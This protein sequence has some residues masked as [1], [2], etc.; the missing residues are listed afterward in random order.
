MPRLSFSAD[1]FAPGEDLGRQ[2]L[3]QT[4]ALFVS[5]YIQE[6]NFVQQLEVLSRRVRHDRIPTMMDF[7]NGERN[8][9]VLATE[10]IP[11]PFPYVGLNDLLSREILNPELNRV[12]NGEVA[13]RRK[14]DLW[15]RL[16]A[17]PGHFTRTA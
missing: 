13:I 17:D 10:M 16:V 6:L 5:E 14:T 1:R 12:Q 2:A 3:G 15:R 11:D 8:L 4:L 7:A 9:Y